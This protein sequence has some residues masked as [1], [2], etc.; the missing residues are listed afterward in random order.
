MGDAVQNLDRA[1]S[2]CGYDER[3]Y[4][5]VPGGVAVVTRLERIG[6]D[7]RPFSTGDRWVTG[8]Y[9]PALTLTEYLKR[10]FGADDGLYRV[11]VFVLTPKPF[12]SQQKTVTS[13]EAT[14]WLSEGL[15]TLP[16]EMANLSLSGAYNCTAL[17]YEFEKPHGLDPHIDIPS[18]L[19]AQQHLAASGLYDLIVAR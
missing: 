2:Q 4:F 13:A 12:G 18:V 14:Q 19:G 15:D 10:L 3:S 16:P 17:I 9:R 8:D 5:L 7:G 11:V 1:L 6:R